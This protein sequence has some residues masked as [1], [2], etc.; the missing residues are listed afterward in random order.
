MLLVQ[1]IYI[2]CTVCSERLP[3]FVLFHLFSMPQCSTLLIQAVGMF[4]NTTSET[5]FSYHKAIW[6]AETDYSLY[7]HIIMLC[8]FIAVL[9]LINGSLKTLYG[10]LLVKKIFRLNSVFLILCLYI[11][12]LFLKCYFSHAFI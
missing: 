10:H 3:I 8:P 7:F 1:H 12:F 5:S 6:I 4:S 2:T 9:Q 11:D